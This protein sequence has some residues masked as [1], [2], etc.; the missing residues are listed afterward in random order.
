MED[1][2]QL[3]QQKKHRLY[4]ICKRILECIYAKIR[5][6]SS[7][8]VREITYTLRTVNF[9]GCPMLSCRRGMK[10]KKFV[11]DKLKGDGF[12][13]RDSFINDTPDTEWSVVIKW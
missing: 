3:K 5:I 12:E 4:L 9:H 2:K 7:C 1:I 13:V 6:A 8:S 11:I 10:M